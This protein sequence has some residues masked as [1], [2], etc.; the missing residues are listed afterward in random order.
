M[1]HPPRTT[2]AAI[3]LV[4]CG[5]AAVACVMSYAVPV[6]IA[7]S[8][9]WSSAGVTWGWGQSGIQMHHGRVYRHR[10]YVTRKPS[11]PSLSD[12]SVQMIGRDG[13]SGWVI[14]TWLP[15]RS[16]RMTLPSG[17]VLTES[18]WSIPLPLLVV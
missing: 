5:L 17:Y 1:T 13:V 8:H 6:G 3:S 16:R 12:K 7:I 10:L 9:E 11:Q 14:Q 2:L 15:Y 18:Q 4:L